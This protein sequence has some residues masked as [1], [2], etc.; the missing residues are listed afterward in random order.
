MARGN[1][2]AV[3]LAH[4]KPKGRTFPS[5]DFP[6]LQVLLTREARERTGLFWAE[7]AR[8]LIQA[9]EANRRIHAAIV[10]RD[11]PY[12]G[13]WQEIAHL[14]RIGVP[15]L[16][17]SLD[18]FSSLTHRLEPEG[19]GI[20]VEQAW[21]PLIEQKPR[22]D[23]LWVVMDNVRTPGNLGTI[24]RTCSAV[25]AQGVMLIGGETDPHDPSAVRASMGAIFHQKLV[26]TS[27]RALVGWLKRNPCNVV[28]TS[29]G[30]KTHY[31]DVSYSGPLLLLMGN[32]RTGLRQ[33]QLDLC[34]QVVRLPMVGPADSLNLAVATG[35]MLY[36]ALEQR[37]EPLKPC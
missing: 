37:R 19:I 6:F 5:I 21:S 23:A 26:R 18:Q 35:V 29:P 24:L 17:L 15:F 31:R 4:R 8:N 33:R 13:C 3:Q 28:G 22:K 9:V 27:A 20:V 32:E 12:G 2:P 34:N 11:L 25:G 14:K 10:C 36:E 30:A 1:A 16:S 7:G